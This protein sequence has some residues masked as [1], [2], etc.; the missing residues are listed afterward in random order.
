[1]HILLNSDQK[2]YFKANCIILGS[3]AAVIWPK[4]L[5]VELESKVSI[6][7]L[8]VTL[9]ASARNSTRWVSLTLKLLDNAKSNCHVAGPRMAPR[10]RLPRV[11]GRGGANAFGLRKFLTDRSPYGLARR[12]LGR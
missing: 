6:R 5:L 8:L 3:R 12:R 9:N 2:I 1:M 7:K 11:P 10:P 4:V